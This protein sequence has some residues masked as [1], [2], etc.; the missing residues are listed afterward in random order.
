MNESTTTVPH[1]HMV[2][3]KGVH[4]CDCCKGEEVD[5]KIVQMRLKSYAEMAKKRRQNEVAEP[6]VDFVIDRPEMDATVRRNILIGMGTT[7]IIL[8]GMLVWHFLKVEPSHA[9]ISKA[10]VGKR[11]ATPDGALSVSA[12]GNDAVV[13]GLALP[14]STVKTKIW[15]GSLQDELDVLKGDYANGT[16]VEVSDAGLNANGVTLYSEFAPEYRVVSQMRELKNATASYFNRNGHY[17]AAISELENVKPLNPFTHAV[18]NP[19]IAHMQGATLI[20]ESGTTPFEMEIR[21]GQGFSVPGAAPKAGQITCLEVKSQPLMAADLNS[22]GWKTAAFFIQG[23]D[24]DGQLIKSSDPNTTL[25][26]CTKNGKEPASEAHTTS[27][28]TAS[29]SAPICFFSQDK[30][31]E[32]NIR[33]KYMGAL[34]ALLLTL[35]YLY[36]KHAAK[37]ADDETTETL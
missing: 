16:W 5:L 33:L 35:L 24:R 10:I 32:F 3:S 27:V 29:H 21:G 26:M 34:A 30:P 31:N 17:P 12:S 2:D 8:V 14:P 25:L 13:D 28:L 22:Y 9:L 4:T 15:S 11:F 19:P 23:Y 7:A 18:Q 20:T 36:G 37:P 1:L 6:M